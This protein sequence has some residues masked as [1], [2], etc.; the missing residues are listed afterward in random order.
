MK[1]ALTIYIDDDAELTNLCGG[2]VIWKGDKENSVTF[3]N[4]SIPKEAEGFYLPMK[5]DGTKETQWVSE[6]GMVLTNPEKEAL[7]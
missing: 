7:Q 3:L 4:E 2:F 1:K 5:S 6:T